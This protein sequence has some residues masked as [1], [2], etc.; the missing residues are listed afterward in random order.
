M[1]NVNK[2][3]NGIIYNVVLIPDAQMSCRDSDPE[4]WIT[5]EDITAA[6]DKLRADKVGEEPIMTTD[7]HGNPIADT[8]IVTVLKGH[9]DRLQTGDTNEIVFG[10]GLGVTE[11]REIRSVGD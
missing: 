4:R 1:K 9:L 8:F 11:I 7:E 6:A 10:P 5:C 3:V 2:C